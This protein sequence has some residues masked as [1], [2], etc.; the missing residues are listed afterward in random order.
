MAL[1]GKVDEFESVLEIH[2]LV[3]SDYGPYTCRAIGDTGVKVE[4]VI[5]LQQ[6]C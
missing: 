2:D 6:K 1:I 3:E 4:V 5:N